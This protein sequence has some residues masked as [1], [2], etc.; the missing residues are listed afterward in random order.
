MWAGLMGN[1][2]HIIIDNGLD[3]VLLSQILQKVPQHNQQLLYYRI[4]W[5]GSIEKEASEQIAVT[6]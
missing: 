6:N 3:N 4:F 2:L 5:K 1:F